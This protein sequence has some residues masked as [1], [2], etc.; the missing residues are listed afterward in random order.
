MKYKG[1]L[2]SNMS[3]SMGGVT[4]SHNAGG[5]YFRQRVVPVNSNTPYQQAVRNWLTILAADWSQTLSSAQRD[6]W[7]AYAEAVPY[8]DALG[9]QRYITGLAMYCA[10]TSVRF[11]LGLTKVLAAPTTLTKP[12]FTMPVY[13]VTAPSTGSLA[14]TNT[15]SWA[16]EVGGAMALFTARGQGLGI[17]YFKGPYRYAGKVSGAATPPT[18]PASI[19]PAFSV[20][21][22][23]RVFY[24]VE[25]VRADGRLSGTGRTFCLSS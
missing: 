3:G 18:S 19:P 20:V 9:E 23:Q 14:F 4:A 7:S 24:R 1:T 12:T 22:G 16:G 10:C 8:V 17:N 21:A 15:D 25:V 2:V 11:V 5:P 13:T 6:A